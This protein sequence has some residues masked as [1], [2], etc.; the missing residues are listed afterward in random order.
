MAVYK[1]GSI[2]F[3]FHHLDNF[4]QPGFFA[5][6]TT[7]FTDPVAD[8]NPTKDWTNIVDWAT[9]L[10]LDRPRLN[11]LRDCYGAL[12]ITPAQGVLLSMEVA[13]WLNHTDPERQTVTRM[14]PGAKK[15]HVMTTSDF[16]SVV[17]A[18]WAAA[19]NIPLPSERFDEIMWSVAKFSI[20]QYSRKSRRLAQ[21]GRSTVQAP[22]PAPPPVQSPLTA[23]PAPAGP[24]PAAPASSAPPSGPSRVPESEIEVDFIGA[25]GNSLERI[26]IKFM[27]ENSSTPTSIQGISWLEIQDLFTNMAPGKTWYLASLTHYYPSISELHG[28]AIRPGKS[29][30]LQALYTAWQHP[31]SPAPLAIQARY[32]TTAQPIISSKRALT[33]E[34]PRSPLKRQKTE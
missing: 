10:S 15:V 7:L 12:G 1:K 33:P 8:A 31:Y 34:L 6:M 30:F 3:A 26:L 21:K 22:I 27:Q 18:R 24:S 25:D 29:S 28:R 11:G 20:N 14:N 4:N 32:D 23:V 5:A 9:P 17:M 2:A 19:F 13:A 16:R